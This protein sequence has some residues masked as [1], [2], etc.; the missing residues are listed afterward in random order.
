MYIFRL[1]NLTTSVNK[2]V[3]DIG[4]VLTNGMFIEKM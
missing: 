1:K 2:S 4:P 3:H